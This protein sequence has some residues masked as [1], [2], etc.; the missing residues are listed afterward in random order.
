MLSLK[1]LSRYPKILQDGKVYPKFNQIIA[2]RFSLS[3]LINPSSVRIKN[4]GSIIHQELFGERHQS[5]KIDRVI[6]FNI[7]LNLGNPNDQ[8]NKITIE[9]N[10][11][12][13]FIPIKSIQYVFSPAGF[14]NV[15]EKSDAYIN[16]SLLSDPEAREIQ[17][18]DEINEL[19]CNIRPASVDPASK[20]I[21]SIVLFRMD[22]LGDFV[23]TVPA[24]HELKSFFPSAKITIFVSP[25]NESMARA[26]Q[27]FDE[28]HALPF[29]FQEKTNIRSVSTAVKEQLSKLV[30]GKHV[31]I[32]IDLSP[33]PETRELLSLVSADKKF[34]FENT[35]TSMIDV[36]VLLH[37]KDPVNYLSN[38]SHSAYPLILIDTVKRVINPVVAHL[39]QKS[40][41]ANILKSLDLSNHSYIVVHSG[42][43]NILVRWP[44]ENFISLTISLS[45]MGYKIVFF[46]DDSLRMEEKSILE[47]NKSIIIIDQKFAFE[48][49]DILLS[50]ASLFIGNDSGPKHLAAM[51]S[52][53]VVSTHSPRTN[54]SE[55]G[56]I[57]SGY[58]ISKRVPCA[59]CAIISEA[60]CGRDLQCIKDIRLEEVLHACEM[61]LSEISS[62]RTNL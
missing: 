8:I 42:A 50:N 35:N 10:Y 18:E 36:G 53:P 20:L 9:L 55:W 12:G 49:F 25:A 37:A 23:L 4:N 17:L 47:N 61:A 1:I 52:V 15:F 34:G 11:L 14:E 48:D 19:P 62:G 30:T 60:E 46:S 26:T 54:W 39:P 13:M 2:L 16:C 59:G 27:L 3:C 5:G 33:M 40:P 29:S 7:W 21:N 44:L 56:Q 58:I 28:V 43:R 22:Q 51:R 31:D 32:A 57:D 6:Y 41:N 45:E 24:I 38:V